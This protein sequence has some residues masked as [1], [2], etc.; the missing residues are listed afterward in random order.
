MREEFQK[1]LDFYYRHLLF[2]E[3][4][5]FLNSTLGF[6]NS[7]LEINKKPRI[8]YAFHPWVDKA[9]ERFDF[10]KQI[11]LPMT[12]IDY[13]SSEKFLGETFDLVI[14][15]AVD[16]FRPNYISRLTDMA[17]GGGLIVIYTNDIYKDKLYR[18]S[19]IRDGVVDNFFED[20]FMRKIR[21][22]QGII[23]VKDEKLVNFKSVN[24]NELKK[25]SLKIPSNPSIPVKLHNLCL[26][27]DQNKAL[28]ESLFILHD[29]RKRILAVTAPR[30][31]GKSA[32]IGLFL[33]YVISL[34]HK[35]P[36]VIVI[37]SPS[38]YSSSEIFRFLITGLK[39]LGIKYTVTRSRDGKIMRISA[40]EVI[41]RWLA[42]DLA[43]DYDGYLIVV[44][45][46]AALGIETLEYIIRKW[47]KTILITTIHGYEG[48]GKA[49]LKYLLLIKQK[50]LFKHVTLDFPIRYSKG[51]PIERFIYDVMLLDAEPKIKQL[52]N[53]IEEV[54][55]EELFKNDGRLRQIYG[56]L[57]S[58]H[59]RNS[60]DDLML[61]GDLHFQKLYSLSDV[62]L[63]QVIFEGG[64]SEERISSI[65]KGESNLGHL[66]P[67]RI[68]KYERLKEFGKLKGWRIIRIAVLP[69]LQGKGLGS[70]LLS[71]IRG[72]A[73]SNNLDWLGSSFILDTRVLNFWVKN[74]FTPIYLASR[75]NE[76]LNGYSVIV[77]YP[78]SD[79]AKELAN[80]LSFNLKRK[81]INTAHQV[82]FNVS[83]LSLA[84]LLDSINAF[85]KIDDLR[86]QDIDKI[87][88]YLEGIL[89]Y[90]SVADSIGLLT[91]KYFWEMP[92][93]LD[94]LEEAVLVGRVLQ[95]KSWSHI[96]YNIEKSPRETE[97]ILRNA[98]NKLMKAFI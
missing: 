28:E 7:F 38:Y 1:A 24:V 98:V 21:S 22:Y 25:S 14:M 78:I 72:D 29:D 43:K 39:S 18:N 93:K 82:Y 58:A 44:D 40:G 10:F 2:V 68:I 42:P 33:S 60:P 71:H 17:R 13:S 79:K 65:L 55:R 41:V 12:D 63:A 88:A 76:G 64:L 37:T 77:V 66:I 54:N 34:K 52:N 84:K 69:E 11:G 59:Y 96:S 56:I 92:I 97:E 49:F 27:E 47:N 57:V 62:S 89:P 45:E 91:E 3:G 90:N 32:A 85:K 87:N 5:N 15:D 46:A 61:L 95:G 48:S 70:K 83:P 4:N 74:G 19:L 53:S 94:L 73:I 80:V 26:S 36:T 50:Y 35:E 81:I 67:H 20:R 51:D 86:S 30:G 8:A 6:L 31:R 9:K 16:D 75:K 23:Y